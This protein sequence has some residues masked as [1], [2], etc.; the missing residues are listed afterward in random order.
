MTIL[1]TLIVYD[2]YDTLLTRPRQLQTI[3]HGIKMIKTYYKNGDS[4]TATYRAL[5]GNYGLH[6]RPPTQTIEKIVKKFEEIGNF[7]PNFT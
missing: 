6:N 1:F 2:Y 7:T 4:A 5:R 3:T